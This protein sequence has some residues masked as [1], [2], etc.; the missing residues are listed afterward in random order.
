MAPARHYGEEL[1]AI[2]QMLEAKRISDFE[3]KHLLTSY[4][5]QD[6]NEKASLKLRLR[7]WFRRAQPGE[8]GGLTL[9]LDDVEKL[10]KAGRA[11]RSK[12]GQL[13]QF[14]DLSNVLRTIGVYLDSKQVELV[15]LEKRPISITLEYCDKLGHCERED[16]SI[17]SFYKLFL[18]L[19]DKRGKTQGLASR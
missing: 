13:T 2:G 15:E 7:N 8:A 14:R 17:S 1:R 6:L 19:Y 9:G 18:E 3:L 11:R 16:R 10:S 5:I 12:P 4:I